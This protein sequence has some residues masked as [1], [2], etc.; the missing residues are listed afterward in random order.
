MTGRD[1]FTDIIIKQ[2]APL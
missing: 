2:K 1:R